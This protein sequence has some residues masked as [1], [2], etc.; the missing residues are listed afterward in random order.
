MTEVAA[1]AV[2][3]D[4]RQSGYERSASDVLRLLVFAVLTGAAFVLAWWGRNGVNAFRDDLS[5]L[6]SFLSQDWE[7]LLA[8]V[9]QI[10]VVLALALALLLPLVTRRFRM[11][12]YVILGEIVAGLV[13]VGLLSAT[14]NGDQAVIL[15]EIAGQGHALRSLPN[16]GTI[17]ALTAAYVVSAPFVSGTW[18][19]ASG[20]TLGVIVV[21]RLVVT[22]SLPGDV[23]LA[24][25]VGPMVGAGVLALFGRPNIHP[26]EEA[27]AAALAANGVPVTSIHAM[28]DATVATGPYLARTDDGAGVFTR[29]VDAQ[30]RSADLL[31]RTYRAVRFKHL[32]DRRPFS[33]LRRAIEHEALVVFAARDA[34]V[35]TPRVRAVSS[36]GSDDVL[37]AFDH[38]DG[39]TLDQVDPSAIDGNVLVDIWT[40]LCAL[41]RHRIAHRDLHL[42][43]LMLDSSGQIWILGFGRGEVAAVDL[44]L[45]VDVAQLL[46]SL[47][48]VVGVPRAVES[49]VAVLGADA[50]RSSLNRLQLQVLS[51]STRAELK[52]QKGLLEDLRD[53]A[54]QSCGVE[55]LHLEPVERLNRR[56]LFTLVTLIALTYFLLPQLANLPGILDQVKSAEWLWAVPTVAASAITYVGAS[57]ALVGSVP[58]RLRAIPSTVAQVATSYASLLAPAGLGGMALNVRYLQRV[59]VDGAVATSAV[60]LDTITGLVVHVVLLILFVGWAGRSTF[61][62]VRLPDPRY[63]LYGLAA[64]VVLAAIALAFPSVRHLVS[65]KLFPIL[66]RAI[67]GLRAVVTRPLKLLMLIGGSVV[68]SLAYIVALYF[69]GRAFGAPLH[70]SQVGAIYLAGSAIAVIAPTPGGLG[71]LEAALIAGFAAAGVDKEIAVPAVFFFRL[72]T[73]WLPIVP[74]AWSFRW[75]RANDYL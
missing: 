9:L 61:G 3:T 42:S 17:A 11:F 73:F 18:R 58:E 16:P 43:R 53:A 20:W 47:A 44:Q 59:G 24:L 32:G 70:F 13:M 60:G 56:T 2:L 33:S 15:K 27:V 68:L 63:F 51:S 72:A 6:W 23:V 5:R 30:Q 37:I 69:S 26:T 46:A 57:L 62:D 75:L 21:L 8:G 36:V 48:A 14:G 1:G 10:T 28:P 50:V 65:R 31:Y 4:E 55:Q 41:R 67:S 45:Q 74:G 19:R 49:A 34:G 12:G 35:R 64:V 71:A 25:T 66:R 52:E 39:R 22:A 40:Q 29:V 54:A 7:R 38:V